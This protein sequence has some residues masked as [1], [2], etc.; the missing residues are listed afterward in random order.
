LLRRII[1]ILG[2]IRMSMHKLLLA[3]ALLFGAACG[4]AQQQGQT[5]AAPGTYTPRPMPSAASAVPVPMPTEDALK[6]GMANARTRGQLTTQDSLDAAAARRRAMVDPEAMARGVPKGEFQ[7]APMFNQGGKVDPAQIAKQYGQL[8]GAQSEDDR[9]N[10]IVFVSLTM[11]EEALKKIG[12]DTRRAG[13]VIVLRGMKYGLQ[14]GTWVKSLEAMKPLA[15]TGANIQVNPELFQQFSIKA[16]PTFVVSAN[17]VGDKGCGDG[18]C[19]AGIASIVGDVS[20]EYALEKISER[21]DAV[22]RIAR[23]KY[24]KL[25]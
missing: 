8:Q 20:L 4:Q 21:R 13:G 9:F 18:S 19:A 6:A 7:D 12:E 3:T 11:P 2:S 25:N 16:V 22:G 17:P 5:Q 1:R 14:P 15:S 24:T 23:Q 10:L